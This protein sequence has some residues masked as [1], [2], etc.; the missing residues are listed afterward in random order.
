MPNKPSPARRDATRER[1]RLERATA[2]QAEVAGRHANTGAKDHK[3]ARE[4]AAQH[5]KPKPAQR[6]R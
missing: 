6:G 1:E 3:G 4:S 5:F 2:E